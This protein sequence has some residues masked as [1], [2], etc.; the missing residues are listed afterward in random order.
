M[1]TLAE[2]EALIGK[3]ET[4]QASH[5]DSCK[6]DRYNPCGLTSS[7]EVFRE[8]EPDNAASPVYPDGATNSRLVARNPRIGR[9]A[10]QQRA[11]RIGATAG[12]TF[13]IKAAEVLG[14]KGQ[15]VATLKVRVLDAPTQ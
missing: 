9:D 4:I 5:Y 12:S 10:H 2:T 11:V 14:F 15:G 7:G 6:R 1:K 3:D 8:G 13:P